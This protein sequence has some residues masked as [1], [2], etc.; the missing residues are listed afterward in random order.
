[1]AAPTI[2]RVDANDKLRLGLHRGQAQVW[3]SEKRFL[4][5]L[6]GTQSGKTS[7]GPWW[8]AR[9]VAEK[10]RGDYLAV[11]SSYDLFKLKMLPEMRTVFERMLGIGRYWAGMNIIELYD[12][13]RKVAP[14]KTSN[15]EMW[16]RI[17]LRS[18]QSEGGLESATA[19][20]AWIDE[21]FDGDTMIATEVGD[22]SIRDIVTK[23]MDVRVWSYNTSTQ[24]WQLKPVVRYIRSQIKKE[25]VKFGDTWVTPNHKYW[26]KEAG[27]TTVTDILRA[28]YNDESTGEVHHVW[29]R[30][31]RRGEW[32]GVSAFLEPRGQSMAGG[33]SKRDYVYNLEI[34]GN[35]NYTANGY[36]VSNCGQ[37]EFRVSAWE[38]ILRRLSLSQGRVLGTTTIYN[39][40]WLKTRIYDPWKAAQNAGQEHPEIDVI[41]YAS[42]MNPAFPQEEFDRARRSLPTW[43]FRMFYQGLFDIPPGL[44]YDV[45]NPEIHKKPHIGFPASYPR[46]VG[47]DPAGAKIG[48]LWLV[49][50][51]TANALTVYREHLGLYGKAIP[52]HAKDI[53]RLTGTENVVKWIGGAKAEGQYRLEWQAA[54]VPVEPPPITDVWLGIDR[55]YDLIKQNKLRVSEA[56]PELLNELDAYSRELDENDLPTMAIIDKESYHLLDS[57]RY[58]IAWLLEPTQ[59][60]RVTYNPVIIGR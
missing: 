15:G 39:R 21:C 60:V 53:L 22:I 16:G 46:I 48:C 25:L 9:E 6:A 58:V 4:F 2:W 49:Y 52:E 13:E 59:G 36:L 7:F 26:T 20:A 29:K 8:L 31:L 17:I 41:Q 38:A 43:K 10:G 12:P 55:V 57:L 54:G 33:C 37:N 23:N 51:E 24:A 18:A 42:V 40:G 11:T 47:I 3:R 14:A 30:V 5:M 1:M 19:N 32:V 28:W 27:Y 45:F 50:E 44:I 34:E 35:H 56:C